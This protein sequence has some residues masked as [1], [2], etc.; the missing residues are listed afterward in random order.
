MPSTALVEIVDTGERAFSL[1][2]FAAMAKYHNDADGKQKFLKECENLVRNGK[3]DEFVL[4]I[5]NVGDAL[6]TVEN[7][8]NI[9][10]TFILLFSFFNTV[11]AG[12]EESIYNQLIRLLTGNSEQ[13]S[14]RLKL[15]S[16]LY[17][18][19]DAETKSTPKL[20]V[21]KHLIEFAAKNNLIDTLLPYLSDC[22]TWIEN[23]NLHKQQ[24]RELFAFISNTLDDCN[25]NDE[26]QAYLIRYLSTFED[27]RLDENELLE[28]RQ[29]ARKA[30]IGYIK[31]PVISQKSN[32]PLMRAV[33]A[34]QRGPKDDP[35]V[36]QLLSIFAGGDVPDYEDFADK[37][38]DFVESLGVDHEASKRTIRLLS[39]CSLAGRQQSLS[40]DNIAQRLKVSNPHL[41][42]SWI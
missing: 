8:Q 23:L 27:P 25:R 22:E 15:L 2:N 41:L 36:Y 29:L 16:E 12:S 19:L 9:E 24:Q 40:Y 32:L 5:I 26:A 7:T 4:K 14:L 6:F 21:L 3:L 10:G 42:Y 31:A 17:N 37:H 11:P 1:A 18:V 35:L 20:K 34:L 39:L 33:Q 13:P 38:K 28:G 30:A